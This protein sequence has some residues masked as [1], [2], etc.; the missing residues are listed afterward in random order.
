[1]QR[2]DRTYQEQLASL[3]VDALGAVRQIRIAGCS[4]NERRKLVALIHTLRI[5]QCRLKQQIDRIRRPFDQIRVLA[6]Y[7]IPSSLAFLK[8]AG[9]RRRIQPECAT[10]VRQK[11]RFL[12]KKMTGF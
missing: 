9:F 3:K 12:V 10:R 4:E 7:L 2:S 11:V 6:A 1:V 8:I 5:D